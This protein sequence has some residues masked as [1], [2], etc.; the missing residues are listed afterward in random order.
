MR[1]QSLLLTGIVIAFVSALGFATNVT[2]ASIAYDHGV[3]VHA[4]NLSRSV[5]FSIALAIAVVITGL[6]LRMPVGKRLACLSLGL[7]FC[8]ELYAIL[9]SIKF[10][11]VG[12]ALL[13]MYAY[14]LMVAAFSWLT[15]REAFT[16]DALC[17]V[18]A[19][20]IGLGL[21]LHA[22]AGE[23]DWRGVGLALLAAV[24]LA[25]LI[26]LAEGL[27]ETFDRR[28]VM[29][30]LSL[31]GTVVIALASATAVEL[32]WPQSET[33]WWAF[34][35]SCSVYVVSTYLLFTAVE[36][37]GPL[38]TSVIDN[39]APVFAVI[40]GAWL[41]AENL[42][43]VQLFGGALV[44]TGVVL[45]QLSLAVPVPRPRPSGPVSQT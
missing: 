13:V 31:S 44:I 33:G 36:L 20:F 21:A 30:H 17:A 7:L 16:F 38:R 12:L 8:L 26:L 14:P 22:P 43:P 40:L 9:L 5:L 35:G 24:G 3:N 25:C 34:A 42:S 45:V 19:A 39:A 37:I 28:V 41:L 15:R 27:M 4:L 10:I 18:L 32:V 11:P 6:T 1:Q 2:L 29:L 23:L